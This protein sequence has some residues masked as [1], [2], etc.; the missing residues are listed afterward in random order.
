[1][2]I[3]MS[4][5]ETLTERAKRHGPFSEH[6][7]ISQCLRNVMTQRDGWGALTPS[8]Q[9]ALQMIVHK[10][11]RILNGGPNDI[12]SWHDIAGYATLVERE[13]GE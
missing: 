13:L 5:E 9:E 12:D 2:V 7:E 6:A 11:A 4:I 8:Q 1:M 3:E 10:I